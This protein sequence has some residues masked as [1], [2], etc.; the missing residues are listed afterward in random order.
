M[1]ILRPCSRPSFILAGLIAASAPLSL[2][3][4]D[5]FWDLNGT[6]AGASPIPSG[7]W[8]LL[9]AN[10]NSLAN[11]T[12]PAT[13]WSDGNTAVF[14]AGSDA[15]IPYTVTLAT[16]TYTTTGL[17]IEEGF[18]SL[19]GPGTIQ[20][21]ANTALV[22]PGTTLNVDSVGRFAN[23]AGGR[24]LLDQG[25]MRSTAAN[26]GSVFLQPLIGLEIGAAGGTVNVTQQNP[27]PVSSVIYAGTI[28]G[29]GGTT[30]NGGAGTLTKTGPQEFRYQGPGLPNTT[31][32]KLNVTEG[33][34]RLG[35]NSD[36]SDERGFGAVPLAFTPDAITLSGRGTIG[37]SFTA[38]N[39]VLHVNRGITLGAGGGQ[40]LGPITVPGAITGGGGLTTT[41]STV[42]LGSA[43]TYTG[44][45]TVNGSTLALGT[46]TIAS[47][48]ILTTPAIDL[49]NGTLSLVNTAGNLDRVGN[50]TPVT[51]RA[52]TV[53]LGA[54]ATADTGE[55]IG[56]LTMHSGRTTVSVASA[57][58]RVTTLTI[59][60]LSRGTENATA[61]I[62]GTSLNQSVA[63][64]VARIA[65]GDGGASLNSVGTSTLNNGATD[66]ATKDLKIVPYF[67]GDTSATGTGN[68]FVTNDTALGLRVLT[69]A[70]QTALTG[71]YATATA[72]EN[73]RV[74]AT[75]TLGEAAAVTVN[76]LLFAGAATTTLGSASTANALT[77]NSGAI[78]TTGAFDYAID[79]SF[80]GLHLG[81]G[82]G[83]ITVSVAAT[84]ATPP[85][86]VSLTIATPIT[87]AS[88]G[89]LT[90]SGAGTLNLT[91]ANHYTGPTT[92]SAGVLQASH[93]NALGTGLIRINGTRLLVGVGLNL[94]NPITIG[95]NTGVAGTGLIEP[96]NAAGTATISGP[97]TITNNAFAG[98]HF[99]S[100]AGSTL[101]VAS[102]ITAPDS[103]T[104][105]SRVG[106]VM[107][108]GGGTG[109]KSLQVQGD[110][111]LVGADNGIAS[112]AIVDVAS[113]ATGALDLN[114]FNQTLAGLTRLSVQAA[115]VTNSVLL[116]EPKTLTLNVAGQLSFAGT[117]AVPQPSGNAVISGNL[118]LMKEGVGIQALSGAGNNTYTG[119]TT[120]NAGTLKLQK[121][122]GNQNAIPAGNTLTIG[123]SGTLQIGA[124]SQINDEITAFT[125]NGG[126]F[127]VGPFVEGIT[128]AVTITNGT[129]SGTS[130]GF[131]LTRG[132]FI[133]NGS[134]AIS[135]GISVRGEDFNSGRFEIVGGTTTVSGVIQTDNATSQGITK[136]GAGT[137]VLSAA[138]TF[139]GPS[140]VNEGHMIVSGSL[141]A[142]SVVTVG[143]GA[144][145]STTALLGGSGVAGD[146]TAFGAASPGASGATVDP[147]NSSNAAGIL[148]TGALSITSGA[149]LSLQIGGTTAGGESTTGYDQ[150]VAAGAVTFTG[151]D[152]KLTLQGTPTFAQGSTLFVV[153]NN[154][155][156]PVTGAFGTMNGTSFN[157][158]NF[159]VNGQPFQLT[160]SANFTGAGSDG[161]SNDVALIAVPEPGAWMAML[162]G[163]A[164]LAG[165]RRS[166]R[167]S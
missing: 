97:L 21:G 77:V 74:T 161:V 130:P 49:L 56:A 1:P 134:N 120:I 15:V 28:T 165:F 60:S 2:P 102:V 33:L 96:V 141:S 20:L 12:G 24:V 31:F 86:P 167:L 72:P 73:V 140:A 98:G 80:S 110:N 7:T 50:A 55:T 135:K 38:A 8:S 63:T 128:P 158:S 154:S 58:S 127:D 148:R 152:L 30:T 82:E 100:R 163:M 88:G 89:G 123:P 143:D 124:D 114:G 84:S 66:D 149:H 13:P 27:N 117:V 164:M 36:I 131:L 137:L 34:F 99:A 85:V 68:N 32:A 101:H 3:A 111:V 125:M 151:G 81:N 106:N 91:V 104:L 142:S 103:V 126:T 17:I 6:A 46:A 4:A 93:A 45:T 48:S 23:T 115:T 29:T 105:T 41:A 92:I 69:A 76:S 144:N 160:Y 22:N 25:T 35:F 107:F 26:N 87:I 59:A 37:T 47:G 42:S 10:W 90:K 112:S 5:L 113:S 162:G 122:T 133:A 78:G 94:A 83:V 132:G 95:V 153:V 57:A 156:S 166:R 119:S 39:S 145:L 62:R 79:S 121:P 109:Y 155:G 116:G 11:G 51:S 65:L 67:F 18:V 61:L 118:S 138:N 19:L 150:I 52:G 139:T 54:N 157:A 146:V 9:D 40:L 71:T 44:T 136:V 159:V 43:N 129:I 16:G 53:S 108:S 147:G 14:A 75:T 64:N 70:Q